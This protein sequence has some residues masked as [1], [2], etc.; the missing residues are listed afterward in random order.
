MVYWLILAGSNIFQFVAIPAVEFVLYDG[1][2]K[3][4]IY[5]D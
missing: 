3:P 1:L 2:S 4:V 5:S